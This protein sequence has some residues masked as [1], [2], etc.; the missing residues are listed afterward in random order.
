VSQRSDEL[1]VRRGTSRADSAH[2]SWALPPVRSGVHRGVGKEPRAGTEV[3]SW[4]TA[5][6]CPTRRFGAAVQVFHGRSTDPS[7]DARR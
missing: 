2:H 7:T 4:A 6:W 3:M 5:A 1:G